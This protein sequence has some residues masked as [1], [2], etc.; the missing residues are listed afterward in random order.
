MD[1]I[2]LEQQSPSSPQVPIN[3]EN[4]ALNVMV[5]F[6]TIAQKR[7]TFSIDE[8]AKI[9]EAIKRF[10]IPSNQASPSDSTL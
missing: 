5:T 4:A 3:D 10:V 2:Q 8:S 9:W 7:G 1:N 6:L